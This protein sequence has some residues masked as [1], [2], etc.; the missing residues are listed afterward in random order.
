MTNRF[1]S[2][3]AAARLLSAAVAMSSADLARTGVARHRIPQLL[4]IG[5]LIRLRRG[6]YAPADLHP[7]VRDAAVLGGRLDCVSLLAAVG[8]FVRDCAHL[9]IQLERHASR[10]PRRP[11]GVVAHWRPSSRRPEHLV[12][13]VI[14]ALVQATR[15]QAPRDAVATLDSAWHNRVVDEDQLAEIFRRLPAR[16]QFLRPM[17]DARCESGIESLM[18]LI[19]RS[20]GADVDIQVRIAGVGRVDFVVDGWL[21]VEC[22][23]RAHHDGWDAQ[24]RDRR[25]DIGAARLGYTTIRP[26]AE[27]VLHHRD[28]VR[29]DI[30]AI[31][32]HGPVALR[33]SGGSRR[34]ARRDA[35]TR[36]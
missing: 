33:N 11:P 19:L 7:A 24:R 8:V 21:I 15:C 36:P 26:I 22:D 35:E 32:A 12:A 30:V 28:R 27:D 3:R 34:R 17:L 6:R 25:R 29:A 18:R 16:M 31:L 13:G 4:A 14:E 1:D 2:P 20:L 9:H 23:S 5:A 10:V